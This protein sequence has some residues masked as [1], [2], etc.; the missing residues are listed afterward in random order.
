MTQSRICPRSHGGHGGYTTAATVQQLAKFKKQV[1]IKKLSRTL[2]TASQN[3]L[4]KL[5]HEYLVSFVRRYHFQIIFFWPP[6]LQCISLYSSRA[7]HLLCLIPY[8]H[9]FPKKKEFLSFWTQIWLAAM[10]ILF[11]KYR[12]TA[13]SYQILFKVNKHDGVKPQA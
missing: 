6:P 9:V 2:A 1:T 8:C 4:F 13:G 11:P 5:I 3:L 10:V 7:V 12:R